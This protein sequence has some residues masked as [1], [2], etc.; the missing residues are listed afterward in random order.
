VSADVGS[1]NSITIGS[2]DSAR[3]IATR[4]CWPPESSPSTITLFLCG[5]VMTGRGID[6]ILR[7]PSRAKLYEHCAGSAL[8][9]VALAERASGAL[10]RHVDPTYVWGDALPILDAV[11]PDARIVNLETAVTTSDVPWPGKGI[12]YRMHPA[13]VDCLAAAVDCCVLAN[14]HVLDWGR[15]GLAETLATLRGAGLWTAGAGRDLDEAAAPATIDIPGKGRVLVFAYGLGTSGIPAAW[16]AGRGCSGVNLLDDL[17]PHAADAV[18]R[19]VSAHRQPGDVVVASVHW[20]GNWGYAIRGDER[21]FAQSLIASGAVD[22][23][24]GHSSHHPKGIEV[25]GGR[26]IVYGCGDFIDDYEGI[27]GYEA[28]RG[29]LGLMYFPRLDAAT[30]RLVSFTMAPTRIGRFRVNRATEAEAAWIADTLT[31]EGRPL[32]TRLTRRGDRL[33]LAWG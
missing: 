7:R 5:D 3:A 14:N 4:S 12:H 21:R 1:S 28:Y 6:Q 24:H 8:D 29:D 18:A 33:A 27:G 15:E 10:P 17:S 26:P 25:H 23:L 22:V 16:A 11:G 30:G 32:G 20:G 31:R 19:Q 2:I 9:Y 13:N